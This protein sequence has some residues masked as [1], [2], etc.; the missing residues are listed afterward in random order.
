[1]HQER[2]AEQ[3]KY[4]GYAQELREQFG[5]GLLSE[6]TPYPHFVVW[7]YTLEQRRLKKRPYNPQTHLPARTNDPG[8]W[9]GRD[10]ALTALASGGYN[11]IG[12]VFSETD[13]FTGTDLD[14]CVAKDG[15]IAAWAQEIITSLSSYTEYSPSKLGVHILTQASLPGTG[16][17][18]GNVEMYAEG[19]FFTITTDHVPGA[20]TTIADRQQQQT[21]LYTS[22]VPEVPPIRSTEN[23]RGSGA[24]IGEPLARSARNRERFQAL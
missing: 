12:F 23:T 8:T 15:T 16:R 19:R 17:K 20:P 6:L 18:I 22:L 7:K 10:T 13:P 4:A 2:R 24:G 21:S 3:G 5:R 11:G 9:T 1:M 14:A